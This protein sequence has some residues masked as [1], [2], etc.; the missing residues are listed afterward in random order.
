MPLMTTLIGKLLDGWEDHCLYLEV[1]QVL[2]G[3]KIG[4]LLKNA[5]SGQYMSAIPG[6]KHWVFSG[7]L[8]TNFTVQTISGLTT[9]CDGY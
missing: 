9:F 8:V 4:F 1:A 6:K 2:V 5:H 7:D 3:G